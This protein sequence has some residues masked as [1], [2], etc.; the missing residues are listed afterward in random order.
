MANIYDITAGGVS[1]KLITFLADWNQGGPSI[2]HRRRSNV[3]EGES[4]KQRREA[5]SASMLLTQY[6]NLL[7]DEDQAHELRQLI[8]LIAADPDLK[9]AVPIMK[10]AYPIADFHSKRIYDAQYVVNFTE[11]VGAAVYA[12]D[13]IPDPLAYKM[14]AP[15]MFGTF[16][17]EPRIT[18]ANGTAAK[19]RLS[20][21][22]DSPYTHRIDWVDFSVGTDWPSGLVPN[23]V[24][25]ITEVSKNGIR[26]TSV[27]EMREKMTDGHEYAP[28]YER[29]AGFL[30]DR[31]QMGQLLDFWNSKKGR[32]KSFV[33]PLWFAPGTPTT[34]APHGYASR[35]DSDNLLFEFQTRESA[36]VEVRL[37]TLPWEGSGSSEFELDTEVTFFRFTYKSPT[38]YVWRFTNYETDLTNSEGTW[39][40]SPMELSGNTISDLELR[41]RSFKVNS[42]MFDGNPLEMFVPYG[43]DAAMKVE[44]ITAPLSDLDDMTVIA[45]GDVDPNE[46]D[47]EGR[48]ISAACVPLAGLMDSPFP[49]FYVGYRCNWR[50]FST[51]C[52]VD[53]ATYLRTGTI[54][55]LSG[56]TV[57]VYNAAAPTDPDDDYYS[58]GYLHVSDGLTFEQREILASTSSGGTHT[59]TIERPLRF[60]S[61]SDSITYNVGCDKLAATCRTKFNNLENCSAFEHIPVDSNATTP[62][63]L[64]QTGKK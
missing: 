48:S 3:E 64:H 52:G 40:Y 55:S 23:W 44:V 19:T 50:L 34:D 49:N 46:V 21:I 28:A 7:L 43:A 5:K 14:L 32:S 51:R 17:V 18:P 2:Q 30:A 47:E 20:V 9:V 62:V 1:A 36:N 13:S 25:E 27:G 41:L 58:G 15:L 54:S 22:E 24:S 37:V 10:D 16:V 42:H 53:K 35:F 33:A 59:F 60:A 56:S 31:D 38:P 4:G 8:G 11:G 61:A 57:V 12:A 45:S 29:K 39:T 63:D 26:R 6:Y